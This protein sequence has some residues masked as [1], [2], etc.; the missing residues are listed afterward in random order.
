MLDTMP[1]ASTSG[2]LFMIIH[3]SFTRKGWRWFWKDLVFYIGCV[4]FELIILE[5]DHYN[6]I[7]LPGL[8]SSFPSCISLIGLHNILHSNSHPRMSIE[9]QL[10]I[11][12]PPSPGHWLRPLFQPQIAILPSLAMDRP[13]IQATDN[14]MVGQGVD[15]FNL[16][17]LSHRD[18][19]REQRRGE[20][21]G[22][23]WPV[24]HRATPDC[25]CLTKDGSQASLLWNTTHS[26]YS[27]LATGYQ[28][29]DCSSRV[30]GLW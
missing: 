1:W 2:C 30:Q 25:A 14:P 10:W 28:S 6:I 7:Q 4:I 15:T 20:E 16:S 12:H 23:C 8:E 27:F 24:P 9:T 11:E 18:P 5:M 17:Q 26:I 29:G 3:L 13:L 21:G 19:G 22:Q